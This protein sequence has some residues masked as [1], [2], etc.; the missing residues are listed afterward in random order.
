MCL[1]FVT[2]PLVL[3]VVFGQNFLQ[4][5]KEKDADLIS[6][7]APNVFR[8]NRKRDD[9]YFKVGMQLLQH[10]SLTTVPALLQK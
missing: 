8:T 10:H 5:R 3:S 2:Y 4:W 6:M 9:K 7:F 1:H